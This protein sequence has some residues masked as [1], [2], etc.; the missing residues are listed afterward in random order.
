[1]QAES[2]K[3][4]KWARYDVNVHV[5]IGPGA[6]GSSRIVTLAPRYVLVNSADTL[7]EVCQHRSNAIIT[8]EPGEARPW[9][10]FGAEKPSELLVRPVS[11]KAQWCWSGPFSISDVGNYSLRL[12][13]ALSP[14][15][16]TIL[17]IGVTTQAR[18]VL[19]VKPLPFR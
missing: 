12:T 17:P 13:S 18:S 1:V 3:A 11:N 6:F 4:E 14:A 10:F 16:Y 5:A 15:V 7:I 9:A 8:L 2:Q 19:S